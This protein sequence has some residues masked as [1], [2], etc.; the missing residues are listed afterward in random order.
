[1]AETPT[2][3]VEEAATGDAHPSDTG[4]RAKRERI[5]ALFDEVANSW[6]WQVD[7]IL[8]ASPDTDKEDI[9]S[10]LDA[11]GKNWWRFDMIDGS[12]WASFDTAPAQED[13]DRS[14]KK[15]KRHPTTQRTLLDARF[16]ENELGLEPNV[17]FAP[18]VKIE[19]RVNM[20]QRSQHLMTVEA[21]S[22]L[23]IEHLN[24]NPSGPLASRE[25][26]SSCSRLRMPARERRHS[27]AQ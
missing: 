7:L 8:W 23:Y 14:E 2:H 17:S 1:M 5:L 18:N 16:V 15:A 27:H 20:L 10:H 4:E 11:L 13:Y 19:N 3:P 26:R 6:L 9:E 25:R 12:A 24:A 21:I 22:D